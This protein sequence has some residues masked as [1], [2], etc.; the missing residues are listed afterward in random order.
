MKLTDTQL[1][2]F[3]D[4]Q[5][6][7]SE[8]DAIREALA[9]HP[10]LADRLAALS[11]VD[12]QVSAFAQQIDGKPISAGLQRAAFSAPAP[13][14]T[15]V[16]TRWPWLSQR[17][18]PVALAAS[19]MLMFGIGLGQWMQTAPPAQ[20]NEQWAAIEAVLHS[21]PSGEATE[22]QGVTVQ[23]YFSFTGADGQL[24]R[25]YQVRDTRAR[26]EVACL[27][28]GHWQAVA[29]VYQTV[30]GQT[31]YS[32]ASASV[33]LDS[34]LNQLGASAPL[35]LEEERAVLARD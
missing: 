34:V 22:V 29:S 27:A 20:E 15:S 4:N 24:C 3:L 31:E 23:T 6:P 9:I 21:L 18:G 12:A 17:S 10:E 7:S 28:D 16:F 26:D 30:A 5:L 33:V 19:V 32:A 35:T 8:M 14:S 13:E 11:Q 25:A 2:A 1:S